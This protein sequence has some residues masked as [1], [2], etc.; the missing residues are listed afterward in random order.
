MNEVILLK[1]RKQAEERVHVRTHKKH[2]GHGA[3]KDPPLKASCKQ[4]VDSESHTSTSDEAS[5]H[6]AGVYLH[7]QMQGVSS[8]LLSR[9]KC[10]A[11]GVD[12]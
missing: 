3:A 10:R 9:L 7:S 2:H 5:T 11:L 8:P 1:S 12:I 6:P 4:H